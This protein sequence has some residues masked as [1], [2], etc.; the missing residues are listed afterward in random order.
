[1]KTRKQVKVWFQPRKTG[2]Y[3]HNLFFLSRPERYECASAGA[4]R[5]AIYPFNSVRGL[6]SFEIGYMIRQWFDP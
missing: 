5:R 4:G 2:P 1:M 6:D 3:T